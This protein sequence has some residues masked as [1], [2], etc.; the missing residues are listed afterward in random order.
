MKKV[1]VILLLVVV[2]IAGAVVYLASGANDFIRAQIESQGSKY[3]DTPVTVSAVDL[4]FTEGRMTITDIDVENPDGFSDEDAFSLEGVT[5]D[6]AGATEEPY[7]IQEITINAPEILYEVNAAGEGN[8]LALKN[9]LMANLPQ[10]NEQPS[11]SSGASP[12]L[13]VDK[14]TVSNAKLMLNFEQLNTGE[15][16]IDKKAYE[17]TLPTFNAGSIGQP[18]GLPADQVGAA[19]VQ[20]MLDNAI[21]Q[22]KA[23]AKKVLADK[24]KEKVQEKIDEEKEK[25]MEKGKDK[26]KDLFNKD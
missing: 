15:L 5:L 16:Q 8:L 3:L 7:R 17:V 24:A 6:L 10:G 22:A 23:E 13:I 1:L 18:D 9:N 11:E 25:L 26:L 12:K 2:V 20:Q 19:I 4:S 14:V 21:K